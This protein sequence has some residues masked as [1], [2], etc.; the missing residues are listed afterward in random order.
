MKWGPSKVQVRVWLSCYDRAYLTKVGRCD[1]IAGET[2]SSKEVN[3]KART[4]GHRSSW[5]AT[6]SPIQDK[7]ASLPTHIQASPP[8]PSSHTSIDLRKLA[9]HRKGTSRGTPI[10]WHQRA[11][12][13]LHH[14][15]KPFRL[16]CNQGKALWRTIY[17]PTCKSV[18]NPRARQN[19]TYAHGGGHTRRCVGCA[20]NGRGRVRGGGK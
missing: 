3:P 10:S 20:P 11:A 1:A 13:S 15:R 16:S 6:S 7:K 12:P 8:Y 5:P 4:D 9:Q 18:Q 19:R 14:S 17:Q 2:K